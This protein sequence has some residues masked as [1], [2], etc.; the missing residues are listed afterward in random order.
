[1]SGQ[2]KP[3]PEPMKCPNCKAGHVGSIL[4]RIKDATYGCRL[5]GHRWA[6]ESVPDATGN[7]T[8]VPEVPHAD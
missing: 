6:R 5:C 8:P 1:M 3:K 7:D 4:F 2:W